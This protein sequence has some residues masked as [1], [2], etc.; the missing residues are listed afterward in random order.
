MKCSLG[1]VSLVYLAAFLVWASEV[2]F[3][4]MS[5]YNNPKI[6]PGNLNV[7]LFGLYSKTKA[8]QNSMQLKEIKNGWIAIIAIFISSLQEFVSK[9]GAIDNTPHPSSQLE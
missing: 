5:K 8:E 7:D 2:E 3:Y 9:V 6:L 4:G 1:K